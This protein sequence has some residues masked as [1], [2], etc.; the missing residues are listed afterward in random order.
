M[1]QSQDAPSL[2]FVV[3]VEV[4]VDCSKLGG[5]A[6]MRLHAMP[7]TLVIAVVTDARCGQSEVEQSQPYARLM[8]CTVVTTIIDEAQPEGDDSLPSPQ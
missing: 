3:I 1:V 2:L 7:P 8:T 6:R 4:I 5:R